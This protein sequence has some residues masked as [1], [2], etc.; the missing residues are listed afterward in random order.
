M[1]AGPVAVAVALPTLHVEYVL[2]GRLLTH[3]PHW[4]HIAIRRQQQNP[5]KLL[6]FWTTHRVARWRLVICD[7]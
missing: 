1:S 5:R 7:L 6:S 2:I 4:I 3:A